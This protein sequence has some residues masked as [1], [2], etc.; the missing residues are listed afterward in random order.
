MK[1]YFASSQQVQ[2]SHGESIL[3]IVLLVLTTV[4]CMNA[5]LSMTDDVK[6]LLKPNGHDTELFR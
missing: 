6:Q 2:D 1:E 5:R 3:R 4:C